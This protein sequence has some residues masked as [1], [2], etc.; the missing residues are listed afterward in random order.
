MFT[1]S[2]FSFF[3]TFFTNTVLAPSFKEIKRAKHFIPSY[4]AS[5]R[6]GNKQYLADVF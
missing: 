1:V 3:L 5:R 4:K 2:N 6:G